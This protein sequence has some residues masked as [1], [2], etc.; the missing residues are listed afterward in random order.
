MEA[1]IH[2][3]VFAGDKGGVLE[4][5]HRINN[6]RALSDPVERME[7]GQGRVIFIGVHR[8]VDDARRHG[9]EAD[10]VRREF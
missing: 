2:M 7:L 5:E 8:S 9:V 1:S 6:V 3:D 10:V 4:I